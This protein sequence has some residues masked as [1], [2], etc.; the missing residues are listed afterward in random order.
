MSISQ[1]IGIC[2][3]GF[4]WVPKIITDKDTSSQDLGRLTRT[5]WSSDPQQ[6]PRNRWGR[7][8]ICLTRFQRLTKVISW[9]FP[10]LY[11]L[12]LDMPHLKL[13]CSAAPAVGCNNSIIGWF[14][15]SLISF[16]IPLGL[17]WLQTLKILCHNLDTFFMYNFQSFYLCLFRLFLFR[18]FELELPWI[19]N[20]NFPA[21]K[22]SP[23]SYD[24]L[25]GNWGGRQMAGNAPTLLS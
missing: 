12:S 10:P 19:W 14:G 16:K 5:E 7:W 17:A 22:L 15:C 2:V 25:D 21:W 13:Y 3:L 6:G 18:I 23:L 11:A 8:G 24:L 1:Y 9:N 4:P 20:L